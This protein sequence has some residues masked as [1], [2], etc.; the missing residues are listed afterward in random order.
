MS[1]DIASLVKKRRRRR[2][3]HRLRIP[4]RRVAIISTV[5][6]A[7]L[8]A[9]S[10]AL[11]ADANN[12]VESSSES[13]ERLLNSIDTKSGTQ[14]TIV[15]FDR[16]LA[17]L[18]DF[19]DNLLAARR[20]TLFLRPFGLL[21]D[22]LAASFDSL[23]AT[24]S[25]T[26]AAQE[27]MRGVEPTLFF[28]LEGNT[29]EDAVI[30]FSSGERIVE[31][32]EIGQASF[33]NAQDHLQEA[34]DHLSE[35]ELSDLS[36]DNFLQTDTLQNYLADLR[37]ANRLLIDMPNLLTMA[38]GLEE[39]RHYLILAQNSDELRPSGGYISTYGLVSVRGGRLVD[40]DYFPSTVTSPTPP[41]DTFADEFTIPDWWL[42][43]Q[44]PIFAAWDGSWYPDFTQTAEL[45]RWY[46]NNGG[47]RRAPVDGVFALDIWGFEA[48]LQALGSVTV[49]EYNVVVNTNNFR[50]VVYDI[51]AFGGD[52]NEHK[53][54]LAALYAQI[55]GDWQTLDHDQARANELI[56]VALDALREKHLM[57]HFADVQLNDALTVLGWNG[58]QTAIDEHDY[59]MVVDANLGNKSNRSVV[60]QITYD[61]EIN[62]NA[63]NSRVAVTYDYPI[64]LANNDP[65]VNPEYHGPLDYRNILQIFVPPG[66]TINDDSTP[67]FQSVA[68]EGYAIWVQ[69]G[70]VDY[71]S[72]ERYEFEYQNNAS[73]ESLG[74]YQRYRL[75]IEK[76]PGTDAEIVAVQIALPADVTVVSTT[77]AA[78]ASYN[79]ERPILDFRL[80]LNEDQWIEVIYQ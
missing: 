1:Q 41:P 23:D 22:N 30:R 44:Q 25:M 56:G 63:I 45:A 64:T 5:V 60:R 47:N 3:R 62:D 54:F 52:E 2:R 27:M 29:G 10:L 37:D 53:D 55:F 68:S 73:I 66:S 70:G 69:R 36:A 7:V 75:L 31:L 33:V 34:E 50:Q 78:A 18:D 77:P 4:W 57:F 71:D 59:L 8:I 80:T 6:V 40:Y 19:Q 20:Q 46:Y 15:D 13:L 38:L 35:I 24:L 32:L 76:Q 43:Y 49:P 14:L 61:V 9:S 65:A 58:E 48:I 72:R 26:L 39:E 67:N 17:G 11:V 74:D 21:D 16:V 42:R 28:V 51:R 12:R 79:L